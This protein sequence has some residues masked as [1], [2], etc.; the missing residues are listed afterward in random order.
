SLARPDSMFEGQIVYSVR[1]NCGRQLAIEAPV[2]RPNGDTSDLFV[3]AVPESA[4]PAALCYALESG[5]PYVEVLCRNR[6]VG[7]CFCKDRQCFCSKL[8][9]LPRTILHSAVDAPQ[10]TC[11]GEEVWPTGAELCREDDHSH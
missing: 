11:G 5:V 3:S 6:Y 1:Q 2:T 4:I 9:L 10:T 7:R 8:H